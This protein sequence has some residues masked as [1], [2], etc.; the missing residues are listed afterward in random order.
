MKLVLD[1]DRKLAVVVISHARLALL[2]QVVGST[3]GVDELLVIAD[4]IE[5]AGF[6]FLNVAPITRTTID[7]LIKRDAGWAATTSDAVL[8]LSDDHRLA[9]GFIAAYR[10]RYERRDDWDI[11][12]PSRYTVRG[13]SIIPLNVGQAE[14]YVGGHAGIYRRRCAQLLPWTAGPHHLNWDLLHT[15]ELI[16]KGARLVYADTD[17]A[18]EDIEPN[19]EPWR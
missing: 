10:D 5:D 9:P 15:H 18:V 8:F 3:E 1:N 12:C 6:P 4:G 14:G 17:L 16:R 19:A 11:L 2:P 13:Q 7:A